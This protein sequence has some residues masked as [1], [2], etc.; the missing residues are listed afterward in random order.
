VPVPGPGVINM[1]IL[2]PVLCGHVIRIVP[3]SINALMNLQIVMGIVA[4]WSP[5]T[6]R[7]LKAP[8]VVQILIPGELVIAI[9][10]LVIL[11]V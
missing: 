9:L 8:T 2:Q 11:I 10:L 7:I 3:V 6:V 1:A 4:I 5:V